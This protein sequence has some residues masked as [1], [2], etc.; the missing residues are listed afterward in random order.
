MREAG[1]LP[2]QLPAPHAAERG[3]IMPLNLTAQRL[4]PAFAGPVDIKVGHLAT[5][6]QR[7]SGSSQT[8]R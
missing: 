6:Q 1:D 5:R 8:S 3:H 7:A 4:D 2:R